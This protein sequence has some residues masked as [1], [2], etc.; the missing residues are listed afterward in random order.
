MYHID[1]LCKIARQNQALL[2]D[3]G[4]VKARPINYQHRTFKQKVRDAWAVFIGRADAVKW[5]EQ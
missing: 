5:E 2:P 1:E 3:K 4:W